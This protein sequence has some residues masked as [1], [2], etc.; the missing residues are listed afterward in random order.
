MFLILR[1][2]FGIVAGDPGPFCLGRG[3]IYCR[4]VGAWIVFL[5]FKGND[6]HSGFAPTEDPEQHRQWVES[7]LSAAWD[8]AGPEN[9]IGYVLYQTSAATNRNAGMNVSPQQIFGNFGT[10]QPYRAQQ[11]TFTSEGFVSLGGE[12]AWAN[13]MGREMVLCLHNQLRWANL[14]LDIDLNTLLKSISYTS[15]DGREVSLEPLPYHP[16]HD[17]SLVMKYLSYY[18]HLRSECTAMYIHVERHGFKQWQI[19][20]RVQI[21]TAAVQQAFEPTERRSVVPSLADA[22]MHNDDTT[23]PDIESVLGR[24]IINGRVNMYSPLFLTCR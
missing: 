2:L 23:T 21:D 9:R 7:Q 24:K 1:L 4:E 6:M 13:R 8:H 5:V 10:M 17:Q 20:T 14:N 12:H 16:R 11:S 19:Q 3:G 22:S 15:I 18:S